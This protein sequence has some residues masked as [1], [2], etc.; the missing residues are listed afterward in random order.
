MK[1]ETYR[2]MLEAMAHALPWTLLMT[3]AS[4]VSGAVLAIPLC[5]CRVSRIAWVRGVSLGL[6][7]VVRS[8]PPIVWLFFIFFG[9]GGE[10]LPLSPLVASILG[11]ALIGAANLAEVYRGALTAVPYGQFEAA[12]VLG[13]SRFH[14][15]VDVLGP[16]VLRVALPSATTFA[17]VLLKDSAIASTIGVGEIASAAYHI[18]QQTFRGIEV[19]MVAGAIYLAISVAIAWLSRS[20]DQRLRLRVAR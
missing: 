20:M 10:L 4:F 3:V 5:A 16:Q 18:S 14:Q 13:L 12:R 19:Y 9:I 7:L 8:I 15:Y 11:L 2:L 1:I 6:V 17:I